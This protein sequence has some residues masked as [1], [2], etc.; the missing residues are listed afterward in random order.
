MRA[1][2]SMNIF[3]LEASYYGG[4]PCL[5]KKRTMVVATRGRTF[6]T[7]ALMLLESLPDLIAVKHFLFMK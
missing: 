4:A 2:E 7:E 5:V 6:R 1:A 3:G